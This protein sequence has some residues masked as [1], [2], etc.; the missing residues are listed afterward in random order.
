MTYTLQL[1]TPVGPVTITAT[2]EAVT[3]IRFGTAVPEGSAAVPETAATPLLLKAAAQLREYFAGT[4][5]DFSLP[6]APAGTPFQQSVWQALQTIPYGETR[7]YGHIAIQIGHNKSFR[8]VGMANNRNPI[9]IVIPCHRV[10][11]YD[12][13]LTGYA[14]GLDSRSGCSPWKSG[15]NAP[16]RQARKTQS[17]PHEKMRGTVSRAP[18]LHIPP[19]QSPNAKALMPS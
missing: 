9:V 12:G 3:Q 11:G 2:G 1:E 16:R 15:D 14:G 7:T 8:A 18:H 17:H 10:L 4:R 6:L 13:K 19:G 5:R